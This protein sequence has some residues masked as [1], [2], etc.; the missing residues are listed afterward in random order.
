MSAPYRVVA[1]RCS[2]ECQC[3]VFLAREVGQ[4]PEWIA[5][6]SCRR[7][8]ESRQRRLLVAVRNSQS[9]FS[10]AA[11]YVSQHLWACLWCTSVRR[12]VLWRYLS[13][14][15]CG[16]IWMAVVGLCHLLPGPVCRMR[17]G[18]STQPVC[19]VHV[20]CHGS[21]VAR[22]QPVV[23]VELSRSVAM[24][25]SSGSSGAVPGWTA[26]IVT[27]CYG[28]RGWLG[29]DHCQSQYTFSWF[30]CRSSLRTPLSR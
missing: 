17:L 6:V 24:S 21:C 25:W 28:D 20:W 29:M 23:A 30:V 4:S 13:T 1:L 11:S 22:R 8:S 18:C 10:G 15:P 9:S 12:V 2:L 5:L 7:F 3:Q 14:S 19:F 16:P 27:E 26:V